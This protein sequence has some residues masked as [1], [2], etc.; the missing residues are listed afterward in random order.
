MRVRILTDRRRRGV[1]LIY[2]VFGAFA[3]A[4]MIAVMLTMGRWT[5]DLANTKRDRMQAQ[6]LAEGALDAARKEILDL[7]ANWGAAPTGGSVT[8]AGVDVDYTIEHVATDNVTIDPSGIQTIV[9][10]YEVEARASVGGARYTA[11]RI[12]STDSTPIFQFAVFYDGDL[13]IQPG[14]SMTLS[15]RVRTNGDMFLGCGNTLTVDTNYMHAQGDIYRHR[16]DSTSS[17][18]TVDVR[19]WVDDPWDSANP[20]EFEAMHSTAQLAA[21]GVTSTS[22]YDSDFAGWDVNGDGD[23]ND[24]GDWLPFLAGAFDFWGEPDGYGESGHTV[25]TGEHGVQRAAAPSNGSLDMF[26]EVAGGDYGWNNVSQTYERVADG[27]GTH[28][29]GYFHGESDLSILVEADGVTW[30]AYDSGGVEVPAASLGG[31]VT[32]DTLYDAREGGDAS[33]DTQVLKIDMEL[34]HASGSFPANGLIYAS[35]YGLDEK[36][37]GVQLH[38]GSLLESS[39]TVVTEGALYIEGD[40]NSVVP[41]GRRPRSAAVIADA[42][43]LLSNGWTGD[44]DPGDLPAATET[45]FNVALITGNYESTAGDYNGG[46]ENLPRFHE[47]WS[48][49]SCNIKGSL[50][51]LWESE[52]ATGAWSIRGDRYRA[53]IRNWDYDTRFNTI[54]NLPPFT[55]HSVTARDVVSW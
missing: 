40:Y 33:S 29:P 15:G 11:E 8:I 4:T 21:L 43:N 1:A 34:L 47:N 9:D 45:T 32:V 52:H 6:Y 14:P 51:N 30:T 22:G 19:R 42:V 54:E 13:E 12:V 38:N 20:V 27:T 24:D 17:R 10:S 23:F 44:K 2:A 5:S 37:Q 16:K 31:A 3:A 7:V 18:G 49:V 50:V 35:H 26:T 41:D 25:Q 28:G 55:P 39:V 36:L 46:L 53:P 48:G